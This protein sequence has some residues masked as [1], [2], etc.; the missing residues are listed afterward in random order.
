MTDT[1]PRLTVVTPD[2]EH[3]IGS[4]EAGAAIKASITAAIALDI[5]AQD[6]AD[7]NQHAVKDPREGVCRRC[8]RRLPLF[9]YDCQHWVHPV[10]I[11]DAHD[12]WLCTRCWSDF[13]QDAEDDWIPCKELVPVPD[14]WDPFTAPTPG[15]L[16]WKLAAGPIAYPIRTSTPPTA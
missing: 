2:G 1:T 7:Y 8:Q 9:V 16:A 10:G 6:V 3:P 4:P 11:V 14:G 12:V 5:A 15:T 13:K